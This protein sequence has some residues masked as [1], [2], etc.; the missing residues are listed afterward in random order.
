MRFGPATLG[1]LGILAGLF[2]A[3]AA[4]AQFRDRPMVADSIR[5]GTSTV[6]KASWNA[7]VAIDALP[8]EIRGK[9]AKVVQSP[10]MTAHGPAEEFPANF[11]DWLVDHPDRV[12]LAWRR[13]GVPCVGITNHGN[14]TFGWTDGQGSDLTW[15]CAYSGAGA[16]VWF[17]EGQA[18]LAAHL[19]LITVRAV[20]VLR[21]A[22]RRESTGRTFVTHDVD[23]YLQTDSRAAALVLKLIGPAAPHLAEEGAGQLLLFFSGIARHLEA[24]PD[25]TFTLLKS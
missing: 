7:P 20:A 4:R 24:H 12:A 2:A 25:E 23:V 1:S 3:N 16:R 14:G 18:R 21:Y 19:P 9:I 6:T 22:K 8:A 10:T 15:R 13:L 11:Y 5:G 17:A